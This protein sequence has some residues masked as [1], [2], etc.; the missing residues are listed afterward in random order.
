M[1][2]EART[3][4][5]SRL[6]QACAETNGE[7]AWEDLLARIRPRVRGELRALLLRADTF[8]DRD[9]TEDLEQEVLC[10]LLERDRWVLARFRG[11]T[12]GEAVLYLRRV[13]ASVACDA[14]RAAGCAKRRPALSPLSLEE[15][16]AAAY[17]PADRSGCPE[18][19]ALARERGRA[20]LAGCRRLLGRRATPD[21]LRA[22]RLAL[23]EGL[24][25]R[26]VVSRLGG[27]WTVAAVDSLIHRLR[28][29]LAA[30]GQPLP[31]RRLRP[32]PRCQG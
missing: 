2:P 21:R 15:L 11:A 5:V 31:G 20:F 28:K 26:E 6:I 8:P 12:E 14:L 9:L 19:R 10:R 27:G 4:S 32:K 24:S 17:E 18:A 30:G 1:S 16:A 22:V 7:Q 13:V 25:S 3:E 23:V 29:R